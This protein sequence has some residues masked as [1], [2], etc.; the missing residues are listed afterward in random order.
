MR[1]K[2][3]NRFCLLTVLTLLLSVVPASALTTTEKEA[4]YSTAILEL[5]SYLEEQEEDAE[6]L[7][8]IYEAFKELKG[9]N[10]AAA[11]SSYV[12]VLILVAEEKF[13][14]FL[15]EFELNENLKNNQ[16]FISYLEDAMKDSP[17]GTVEDLEN[18]VLG[19]AMEA[20]GNEEAAQYYKACLHFFDTA[21]RFSMLYDT[22]S[23]EHYKKGMEYMDNGDL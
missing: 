17:I 14:S 21:L 10:N 2:H 7:E 8:E 16:N 19:R 13:D 22:V 5:E 9:Y 20:E 23:E 3:L 11:F 15:L 12:H 4:K 1:S 6:K 18:Y